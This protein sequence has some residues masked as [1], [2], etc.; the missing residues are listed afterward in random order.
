MRSV[1]QRII[2]YEVVCLEERTLILLD[3]LEIRVRG[4]DEALQHGSRMCVLASLIIIMLL[5]LD[6]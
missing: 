5:M 6:L 2:S 1:L 3:D 4:G